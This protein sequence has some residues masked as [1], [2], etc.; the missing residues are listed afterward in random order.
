MAITIEEVRK[1]S[2]FENFQDCTWNISDHKVKIHSNTKFGE[3]DYANGKIFIRGIVLPWQ[4][5][6]TSDMKVA[7]NDEY[8]GDTHM[9]SLKTVIAGKT[10]E[11]LHFTF[12]DGVWAL[13]MV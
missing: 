6:P 9:L 2:G 1:H 5:C 4:L 7:I 12:A 3:H 10:D 13:Y 11:Y 8:L